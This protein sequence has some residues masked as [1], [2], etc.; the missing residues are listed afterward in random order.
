MTRQLSLRP[1]DVRVV[2]HLAA[3]K[4]SWQYATEAELLGISPSTLHKSVARLKAARLLGAGLR[5]RLAALAEF[6]RYAVPYAF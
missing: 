5:P 3:G 1:I 4:G 2:R 6:E